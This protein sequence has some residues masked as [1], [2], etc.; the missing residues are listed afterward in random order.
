M[1]VREARDS[2]SQKGKR[3]PKS[4]RQE[5]DKIRKA[6]DKADRRARDKTDRKARYK[7]DRKARD[8]T[9]IKAKDRDSQNDKRQRQSERQE[10]VKQK[11]N[12]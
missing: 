11:C 1:P 4:E 2:Q 12:R 8:K 6:K 7:T 5:T 9:D 3:Q 10:T